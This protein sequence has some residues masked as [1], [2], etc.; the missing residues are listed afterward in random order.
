MEDSPSPRQVF[1]RR[2]ESDVVHRISRIA[3]ETVE[4]FAALAG[5]V[6][7]LASDFGARLV[8]AVV[9]GEG[10]DGHHLVLSDPAL[11]DEAERHYAEQMRDPDGWLVGLRQAGFRLLTN[12]L[13][14][15]YTA[16]GLEKILAGAEKARFVAVPFVVRG[17]TVGGLLVARGPDAAPFNEGDVWLAESI[18][19]ILALSIGVSTH[20]KELDQFFAASMELLCM[21][22]EGGHL[23]RMNPQWDD[24]LG[25]DPTELEGA[26]FF[27][28]VHPDDRATTAAAFG[29]LGEA[30]VSARF[31][32][33]FRASD[34]SYRSMEWLARPGANLIYASARDIT[35]HL[36]QEQALRES[37][38][39]LQDL[40]LT[41]GD[42]IW[43]VDKEG[44]YIAVWGKL[45]DV[46]GYEPAEVLG[47]TPFDFMPPDEA[48]RL[49]PV[50]AGMARRQEGCGALVNRNLHKDGH[51]VVLLT[52]CVPIFDSAG[53]FA[54][55]RGVDKDITVRERLGRA[56]Q[57]SEDRY[58]LIAQNTNDVIILLD[59]DTMCMEYV[60]P[61]M[62]RLTGFAP[63]ELVG[64]DLSA[65]LPPEALRKA[66]EST[67][68]HKAEAEAGDASALNY[69][70]ETEFL[71]K[72]GH[73]VPVELSVKVLTDETGKAR[74]HVSLCRDITARKEAERALRESEERFRLIADNVAD[75]IWILDLGTMRFSYVSPSVR[76]LRGYAPD[77]VMALDIKDVVTPESYEKIIGLLQMLVTE[78]E[79]GEPQSVDS[80]EIEQPRKDGGVVSTEIIVRLLPGPDGKPAHV[81]G[82]SRDITQRL[83]AEAALRDSRKRLEDLMFVVGD[84]IW[85]VDAGYRYT[86][87]SDG[88]RALLGYEPWEVIGKTPWDFM[89]PEDAADMR[90]QV[91]E[92]AARNQGCSG[93]VNRNRHRDGQEVVLLTSCVPILNDSDELLGYRGID[94][95][96]TLATQTQESLRRSVVELNALWQIAETVAGPEDLR[97]SLNSVTRQVS[98]ALEARFAL[99]VTF[100]EGGEGR[101]VVASTGADTAWCEELFWDRSQQHL[102]GLV[103]VAASGE[104][105]VIN[106]LTLGPL[107][108]AMAAGARA[109]GFS[110]LL[111]VPLVLQRETIGTLVVTRSEE[112]APFRERDIEFAQA[113]AGSA[114]AAVVH[115]RLRVEENL[116]TANA[117]RDHLARELHDAVTQSVYSASLIAQALPAIWKR[118]PEDA[119]NGLG[120]I[121]RLVRSALAELRILLYE[122]RPGS[123]AGVGLDQLLDRLGDSL[124]GQADVTVNIKTDI[125]TPPPQEVKEAMYRIAQEAFNNIAKHAQAANV[126]ASVVSDQEGALLVVEDDGVGLDVDAVE[127]DHHGLAIMRER[128][129]EIG[130]RLRI[131]RMVPAGTRLTV[132]WAA[133]RDVAA[134]ME[135]KGGI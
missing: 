5:I 127:G 92:G 31:V 102:P 71:H 45:Q 39:R 54:G 77:E 134:G 12:D 2:A 111:M 119:M 38:T 82:V 64:R 80:L 11:P 34:G 65:L 50:F 103:K 107:P 117:V 81:L 43:E 8:A 42:W 32:N 93:M 113:A 37:E 91:F 126:L 123:L 30:R 10:V 89:S 118:S 74:K 52:A 56:L 96:I 105:V 51:E 70:I 109:Q 57:E 98:D 125:E 58:R 66:S 90:S 14:E 19:D 104:P 73:L 28:L 63:E 44:R 4:P 130:A 53:E 101:H 27:D 9:L 128:A 20:S 22:D 120:Q 16:P 95:D 25:Y 76:R 124:A 61:S 21:I 40:V 23:H 99:V 35:E 1:R 115:A 13:D 62:E 29:D 131:D 121:Q 3:A 94:K 135:D 122:L 55:L 110:R 7:E 36:L 132:E 49:A 59:T 26:V 46:I 6:E 67:E 108:P 78:A 72:R 41:T 47:H 97:A 88:V 112:G 84:W 85:E 68:S 48:A 100:G 106:N 60:S 75:V 129:E 114:A 116:K 86:Q 17:A 33:R 87:S 69:L 18:A 79:N 83:A 133:P 24:I 15:V